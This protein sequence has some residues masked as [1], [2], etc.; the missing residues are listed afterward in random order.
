MQQLGYSSLGALAHLFVMNTSWRAFDSLVCSIVDMS[1]WSFAL[2]FISL[3]QVNP[4]E[5]RLARWTTCQ[6]TGMPLQ[7]PCVCD[8]LGSLYNKDAVIQ[9]SLDRSGASGD[10]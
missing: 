5:E 6:L 1:L 10:C 8:E 4:E 9:V 7:P 2:R 3:L